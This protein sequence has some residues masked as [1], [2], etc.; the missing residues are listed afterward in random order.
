[1]R[2]GLA[3][4]LGAATGVAGCLEVDEHQC[5]SVSGLFAAGDV[6][7]DLHQIAVGTGHAAIAATR[8]HKILPAHPR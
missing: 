7:S 5:T 3:V 1:V 8:I 2:S 6:V 4:P